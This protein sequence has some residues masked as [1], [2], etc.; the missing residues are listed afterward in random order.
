[1]SEHVY[2]LSLGLVFGTI[3]LIFGIRAYS[4]IQ[5]AKARDASEASYRQIA[6]KAVA[7]ASENTTVLASIQA[8]LA[9]VRIRLTAIEKILKDVE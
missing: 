3:L 8:A 2:F 7:A 1:M 6:E 9:E 4:A 5:Q